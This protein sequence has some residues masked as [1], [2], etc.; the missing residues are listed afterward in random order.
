MKHALIWI[1]VLALGW[2]AP[3]MAQTDVTAP[4][5]QMLQ[6]EGYKVSE[7]RRT[8]LGRILIVAKKG[9]VLREVVLNRRSGAILND[10]IFRGDTGTPMGGA[11]PFGSGNHSSGNG[12]GPGGGLGGGSGP[13]G[14]GPGGGG[15]GSGPGRF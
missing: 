3:A 1:F 13:G 7:V 8:W 12:N 2:A 6:S 14:G 11:N 5:M 9:A 10:Q 15:G 4:V